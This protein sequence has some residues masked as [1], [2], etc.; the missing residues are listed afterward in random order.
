MLGRECSESLQ[1]SFLLLPQPTNINH[2]ILE[3]SKL[4]ITNLLERTDCVILNHTPFFLFTTYEIPLRFFDVPTLL[5][6]CS[7]GCKAT[8]GPYSDRH[9]MRGTNTTSKAYRKSS[10]DNPPSSSSLEPE[11]SFFLRR[12]KTNRSSVLDD[13]EPVS[14]RF[15]ATSVTRQSGG[16]NK[17][18]LEINTTSATS[19]LSL[20]VRF[21]HNVSDWNEKVQP[22]TD[23]TSAELQPR[24]AADPPRPAREGYEWVW[25]PE[26]YWAERETP[27]SFLKKQK[28]RKWF[29][30]SPDQQSNSSSPSKGRT[31]NKTPRDSEIPRIKIGSSKSRRGSSRDSQMIE[32]RSVR[33]SETDNPASKIKRGLQFVSPTHPYFTS[34]T[35]QPEGLYCKVKRNIETQIINKPQMVESNISI[36]YK[37]SPSKSVD[38]SD[39][40]LG[41]GLPSRTTLLLEGTTNY[42]DRQQHEQHER[43]CTNRAH[44]GPATPQTP[45]S[46]DSR[47]R[48]GFGLAPWHRKTSQESLLSVSSSV[49]RLLMGRP[50]AA[51]PAPENYNDDPLDDRGK[52]LSEYLENSD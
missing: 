46:T 6:N 3:A 36:M 9:T 41:F 16:S 37:R 31:G 4:L 48:R 5:L 33:S 38:D 15:G 18:N 35:G 40:A 11:P 52:Y 29:N 13:S 24:Y 49:H 42:F 20:G 28:S 8:T 22:E 47:P 7:L 10:A 51:T 32:D 25:F 12:R 44:I 27:S 45:A 17:S 2:S 1:C 14:P 50:P 30:K 21:P 19:S 23:T 39:T 34:P 43:S 26:G